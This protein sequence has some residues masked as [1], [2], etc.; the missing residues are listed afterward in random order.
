MEAQTKLDDTFVPGSIF[1]LGEAPMLV[2]KFALT[3][4]DHGVTLDLGL[5]TGGNV[6]LRFAQQLAQQVGVLLDRL[7]KNANWLI[8]PAAR[9]RGAG[10]GGRRQETGA[11]TAAAQD[12]GDARNTEGKT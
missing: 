8:A 10:G 7:Q 2:V 6:N 12:A 3:P 4:V 5:S 9:S 1:P 11:L